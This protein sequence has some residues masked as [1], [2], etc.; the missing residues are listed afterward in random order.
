MKTQSLFPFGISSRNFP[1]LFLNKPGSWSTITFKLILCFLKIVMAS[2]Y[3]HWSS[4]VFKICKAKAL[5]WITSRF[6]R[7]ICKTVFVSP[8][9]ANTSFEPRSRALKNQKINNVWMNVTFYDKFRISEK[10]TKI[11]KNILLVLTQLSKRQNKCETLS[12][13]VAFSQCL[14]FLHLW[15]F[16]KPIWSERASLRPPIHWM[17]PN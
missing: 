15:Y 8:G 11:G 4:N 12:K 17:T 3:L 6:P 10:A 13:F 5:G 2:L 14:N 9:T 1:T 7:G 16:F